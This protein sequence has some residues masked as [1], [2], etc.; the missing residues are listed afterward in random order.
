MF[1]RLAGGS[2][3]EG[4]VASGSVRTLA[5]PVGTLVTFTPDDDVRADVPRAPL[6][7]LVFPRYDSRA[8]TQC[9][10]LAGAPAALQLMG[11]LLNAR[12][13]EG[14]GFPAVTAL[15]RVIPAYRLEYSDARDAIT[16]LR[17]LLDESDTRTAD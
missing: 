15:A 6:R 11:S 12:N 13:L 4:S 5:G 2:L 8:T 1:E 10:P 7:A 14:H 17:R 16:A 3:S 9:E